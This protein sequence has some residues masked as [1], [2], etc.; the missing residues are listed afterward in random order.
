AAAIAV[1]WVDIKNFATVAPS[2][3]VH[4][5]GAVL[6][7]ATHEADAKAVATG[8]AYNISTSSSDAL[9]GAAIGFNYVSVQS[10]G[11]IGH[12]A[13]VTGAGVTAEAVTPAGHRN[14]IV[15]W[16][17]AA[18][19]GRSDTSVAASIGVNVANFDIEGSIGANSTITSTGVLGAHASAPIGLQNL[20]I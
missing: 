4:G 17:L 12:D 5:T 14:D 7:G 9:V 16:G 6:V 2:L 3:T 13:T 10:K 18:A 20:A 19:G 15:V 8:L 11:Q 1:N